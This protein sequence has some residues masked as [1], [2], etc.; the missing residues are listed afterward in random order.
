LKSLTKNGFLQHP[1]LLTRKVTRN[2]PTDVLPFLLRQTFA[3]QKESKIFG[4]QSR[5]KD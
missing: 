4:K 2:E 5:I 1:K 3:P